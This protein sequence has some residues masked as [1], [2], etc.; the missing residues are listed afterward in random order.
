VNEFKV[1]LNK[2][3]KGLFADLASTRIKAFGS[4]DGSSIAKPFPII[5][6]E[7]QSIQS[8]KP[9]ILMDTQPLT[10]TPSEVDSSLKIRYGF[11]SMDNLFKVLN[12]KKSPEE[13]EEL[14]KYIV[15]F[16]K[17]YNISLLLQTAVYSNPRADITKFVADFV[18]NKDIS[19]L[20]PLNL[21]IVDE[22]KMGYINTDRVFR[23]SIIAKNAQLRLESEF[24]KREKDLV[25]LG[26]KLKAS[27]IKLEE[28]SKFLST[29]DLTE[30]QKLLNSENQ[31]FQKKRKEFQDDLNKRKNEE[32]QLVLT[33]A[34]NMVR[35]VAEADKFELI[36]QEAV[37]INPKYDLTSKII[38]ALK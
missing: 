24:S 7:Q 22:F 36:L 26:N 19:N 6:P 34:N 23:E 30:R 4:G 28:D 15:N 2:F 13:I 35:Q 25:V 38:S 16:C 20:F 31:D 33:L 27:S 12:R 21:P 37:Y 29:N 32:F 1:Y 8:N 3:P 14:N 18:K 9:A 17:K 5:T 11:I 10:N